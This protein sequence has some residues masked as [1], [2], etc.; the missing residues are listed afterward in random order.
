MN[1]EGHTLTGH[2]KGDL[3]F[4]DHWIISRLQNLES[5]VQQ[6]F[7]DYRFDNIA[8]ALYHFIWDEYCDWYL[9]LAKVQIQDGDAEQQLGTRRTLI[10]VL[11]TLLRLA[12][13]IIPFITEELWQKVSL[14]AGKRGA[15]EEASI[16]VQPYPVCNPDLIDV[17]AESQI[18]ELKAQ[19]EAVRA[20]RGEMNVSPAQRV[21]LIAHGDATVLQRN[22]AYLLAL[23]KLSEVQIVEH[24][25][26]VEAPVQIVGTTELML[27]I[28]IDIEAE[29][30][31]LHKEIERLES[32]IAKANG[33]LSNTR[34]V[35]RAPA[36]V[37]AQEKAR[38]AQFGE[39]QA[40]VRAQLEKLG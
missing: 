29:R 38:V 27:H 10:R 25:P 1:T 31:R 9:E 18:G 8:N 11:E 40:R 19:V 20:L 26:N 22:S 5:E 2:H 3:S 16:C 17:Q 30:A 34:F 33:K 15:D 4:A 39:T 7:D 24:L 32:E 12:H 13:P 14:D 35:E 6:G 23:A 21:P 36:A 28:E 37:V